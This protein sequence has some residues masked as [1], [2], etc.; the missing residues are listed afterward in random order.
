MKKTPVIISAYTCCPNRG[1]EPGNGWNWIMNYR[2]N[3]NRVVVLTS[4]KYKAEILAQEIDPEEVNFIFLDTPLSL[5]SLKIPVVG[6]YFH[7][8]FWLY[9]GRKYL[10]QHIS[11]INPSHCHHIT[12]SSIKFGSPLYNLNWPIILG[13]LG[14]ASKPH[15][16]LQ[17]YFG[18]YWYGELIKDVVTK[19]FVW[20]NPTIGKTVNSASH[21]LVSNNETNTF[22]ARYKPKSTSEMFDAGLSDT[23]KIE[24]PARTLNTEEIK[25]LWVGR[26]LSR[27]GLNLAIDAFYELTKLNVGKFRLTIIG[28]GALMSK[29]KEQVQA[30]GLKDSVDFLGSLSHQSLVTHYITSHVFLFPSLKDSCPMQVFEAMSTGLPVVSL[31]HQGMMDQIVKDTGIKV[32]VGDGIDY[33]MELAF[34]IKTLTKNKDEYKRKSKAAYD[35]GQKQIWSTRIKHFFDNVL[36]HILTEAR[37]TQ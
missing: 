2:K 28:D 29:S 24:Y 14:G 36:P 20:L 37:T 22:L 25:V 26:M 30:Y 4:N 31:N 8:F 32:N 21:I 19:L 34:A 33:A 35:H 13:P 6:L 16:S 7:Y 15:P 5:R 11:A 18:K 3:E 27:K 9:Y 12:Y 23:F 1:S 17:K 10:N